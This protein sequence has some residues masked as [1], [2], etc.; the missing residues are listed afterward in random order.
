MAQSF[1][2]GLPHTAHVG[3]ETLIAIMPM[4]TCQYIEKMVLMVPY[5][6]EPESDDEMVEVA[7]QPEQEQDISQW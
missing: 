6:F 1:V 2:I 5:Q 4:E 3:N 7:D